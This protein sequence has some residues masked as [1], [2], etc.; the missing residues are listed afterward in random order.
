MRIR[1]YFIGP[2]IFFS[3][4]AKKAAVNRL[5]AESLGLD[6]RRVGVKAYDAALRVA[7]VRAE[8]KQHRTF[9]VRGRLVHVPVLVRTCTRVCMCVLHSAESSF[10]F[11]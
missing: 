7:T 1:F 3:R 6:R 5:R 4:G 2:R 11:L 10:F 9:E 8:A